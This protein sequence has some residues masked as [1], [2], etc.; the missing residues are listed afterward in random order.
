MR[1]NCGP[2]KHTRQ[3]LKEKEMLNWHKHFA[4]LPIRMSE[5]DCRWLET[6]ERRFWHWNRYGNYGSVPEYRECT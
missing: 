3:I 5:N 2:D 4:W 1:F 6:V